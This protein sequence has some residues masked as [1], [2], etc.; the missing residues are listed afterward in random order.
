M[1]AGIETLLADRSAG[2]SEIARNAGIGR[3]TLY[4]HFETREALVKKLA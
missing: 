1:R 2:M 3:A 4:R